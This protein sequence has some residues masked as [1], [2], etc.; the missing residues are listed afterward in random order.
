MRNSAR[1]TVI[2]SAVHGNGSQGAV[3][4]DSTQLT[5][6]TSTVQGN[7]DHGISITDAA[8]AVLTGNLVA[9]NPGC[10]IYSVSSEDVTGEGNRMSA[11][12]VD[13]A[14]N[15][16]AELRK[17]LVPETQ[18]R[19]L[20]FPGPY[21]SLQATVD[22]LAPGGVLTLASGEHKGG[23]TVWKP[24]TLKGVAS[25]TVIEGT[26]SLV[27][28]AQGVGLQGLMIRGSTI[29]GLVLGG[30]AQ[31]T[32]RTS[33]FQENEEHGICVGGRAQ[34]TILD[35]TASRNGWAGI[36]L[37]STTQTVVQCS[38]ANDNGGDGILLMEHAQ[39][40]VGG[41]ELMGNRA[42]GVYIGDSAAGQL[43][44]NL[45]TANSGYG[46]ALGGPPCLGKEEAFTGHVSGYA[47]VIPG[48]DAPDGNKQGAVCP[49][50][51]VFLL[52]L[53]PGD[54]LDARCAT[55]R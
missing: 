8:R 53:A 55:C 46:V 21:T 2:D 31:A 47:N 1:A 34:A 35:C 12:G 49:S 51:L 27:D 7:G 3:A 19:S 43:V 5:V 37:E 22:A 28:E 41:C 20:S 4:R 29:S 16:G 39:A 50:E 33:A 9:G 42:N 18:A 25:S 45:I 23:V 13:L 24:L 14:G 26:V 36:A 10:G 15:L 32:I 54:E 30:H 6:E 52:L 48:P 38:A 17:P 11:N 40:A 44:G